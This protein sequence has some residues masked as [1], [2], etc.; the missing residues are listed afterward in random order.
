MKMNNKRVIYVGFAFLLIQAFW[1]AYDAI[2]PLMLVNK[3]G[4]NQTWSGLIMALDNILAIFMLPLFGSISDKTNTKIGK[5]TPYIFVGTICAV[6][7]FF[8]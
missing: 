5:R 2:V 8:G 6:I 7:A 4:M 1:I 3:F